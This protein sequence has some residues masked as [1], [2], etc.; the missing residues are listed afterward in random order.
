MTVQHHDEERLRQRA[1][2]RFAEEARRCLQLGLSSHV[3]EH[4][5]WTE[6]YDLKREAGGRDGLKDLLDDI[7]NGIGMGESTG[8]SS[9]D[10]ETNAYAHKALD[11][12]EEWFEHRPSA[13]LKVEFDEHVWAFEIG[14]GQT[15]SVVDSRGAP[16]VVTS[17]VMPNP[18]NREVEP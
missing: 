8:T 2:H 9:G 10:E 16:L 17:A 15:I 7:R 1:A 6:D 13:V 5:V 3:L 4:M 12:V 11:R 14:E 18:V